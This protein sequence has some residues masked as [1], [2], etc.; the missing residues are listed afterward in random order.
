VRRIALAEDLVDGVDWVVFGSSV[1]LCWCAGFSFR[2][3]IIGKPCQ[4]CFSVATC[5]RFQRL[6]GD[7]NGVSVKRELAGSNGH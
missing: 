6:V 4:R 7:G 2:S 1:I 3:P 5:K